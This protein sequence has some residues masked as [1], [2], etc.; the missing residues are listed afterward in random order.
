MELS[1]L[2]NV[3]IVLHIAINI[4]PK[5]NLFFFSNKNV[6]ESL[7]NVMRTMRTRTSKTYF[8]NDYQKIFEVKKHKN[9]LKTNTTRT[10]SGSNSII[11]DYEYKNLCK[12]I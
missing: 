8:K 11:S 12:Y 3:D 10:K 4:S 2:C 1:I 7:S 5:D 9:H 6:N